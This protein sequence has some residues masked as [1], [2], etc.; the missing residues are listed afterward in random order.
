MG[1]MTIGLSVCLA[2]LP[3]QTSAQASV[4]A[5]AVAAARSYG[6]TD[7]EIERIL[8]GD[9]LTKDLKEGSNK[10][11]AGVAAVWLPKPI[12]EFP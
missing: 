8:H 7:A 10:E 9:I 2:L 3:M 4:P 11:L 12:V 1:T 5:A 6:F